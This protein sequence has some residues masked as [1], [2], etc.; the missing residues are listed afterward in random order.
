MEAPKSYPKHCRSYFSIREWF[1]PPNIRKIYSV[2]FLLVFGSFL[3]QQQPAIAPQPLQGVVLKQQ[4]DQWLVDLNH[5]LA[6]QR[7]NVTITLL[8]MEAPGV[9]REVRVER[10]RRG[11][12]GA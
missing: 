2:L 7:V 11:E 1:S 6:G 5:P 9:F 4:K 8:A 10:L 12:A 3:R